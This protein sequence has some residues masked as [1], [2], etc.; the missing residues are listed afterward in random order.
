MYDLDD[1]NCTT[2]AINA[3]GQAGITLPQTAGSWP[4]GGGLNPGNFGQDL[5]NFSG[6]FTSRNTAGGISV[7]VRGSCQ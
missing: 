5:R 2:Y 7:G 1:F 6:T 4:L 3:F